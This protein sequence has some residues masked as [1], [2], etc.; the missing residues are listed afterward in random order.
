MLAYTQS[1][2]SLYSDWTLT[3][4][5]PEVD[6]PVGDVDVAVRDERLRE[7]RAVVDES[8]DHRR[9]QRRRR[10]RART[11]ARRRRSATRSSLHVA[12]P[13]QA[14][15]RRDA[16]RAATS[17]ICWCA[18]RPML[19]SEPREYRPRTWVILDDVSAS[20]GAIELRAQADLVD[21]FLRELDEHD[22]RRGRRVRRRGA[23]EARADARD[24]C[25]SPRAAR[26]RCESEG[27]VGATDFGAA[28]DAATEALAR[29]EPRRRDDRLSRRRRDHDGRAPPRCAA[30]AARGQGAL[31]RRR[32]RR[33]PRHADARRARRRDRRLRD[34]DRSRRR[35][36][37]ARVRS[38]RGA[39]HRARHRR[40]RR[41]SSTRPAQLVPATA[42]LRVAAARRRRGA[43][44]RRQAR[45]HRHARRGRAHRHARRRAVVRSASSSATRAT[46]AATC[47]GCGRSVTSRRACSRSTSRSCRRAATGDAVRRPRTSCA[48]QRDEADPPGVVALGKQYFLLS[49]HTSL[50][51]LENDAMYAQYGVRK[52]AGDTWAP[53]AMPDRHRRRRPRRCRRCR[54]RRRDR[55][56]AAPGL[57]RPGLARQ[58][59]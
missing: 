50:L 31:H 30:R 5:L 25:R 51:V 8:S 7:L 9:A 56:R 43:R 12:R 49:R 11:T 48:K 33:R 23:P 24:R 2:P 13:A 16:H 38:G 26:S 1:L 28:L 57:L 4:P 36:R 46:T 14:G 39:A 37:L 34:D 54:R 40:S 20:R 59:H 52:G 18:R 47:R 35:P 53:Y 15:D 45:R 58:S 41:G 32:H 17:I 6:Q 21:A 19:G 22:K 42:Y 29:P 55:A 27:G 3:V 44:A 10:D